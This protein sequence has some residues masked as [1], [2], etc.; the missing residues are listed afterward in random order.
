MAMLV[1]AAN[2]HDTL[3]YLDIAGLVGRRL[4]TRVSPRH[5]GHV[6]GGMMNRII[7]VD[8]KA[9][10]INALVINGAK[11]LPGSGAGW[12]IERYLQKGTYDK[13][14]DQQKR[15]VLQPVHDAIF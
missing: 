4:R 13:L 15:A 12:Y 7:K 8:P 1:K 11:K 3:T 10:P 6:V 2:R 5:I 14:N 9:P